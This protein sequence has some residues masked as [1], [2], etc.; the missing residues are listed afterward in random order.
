MPPRDLGP[1][2]AAL[3]LD[4]DRIPICQACLS[5]VSMPLGHGE[6]REAK[7]EARKMAPF[8]WREGLAEPVLEAV[9]RAR[10]RGVPLAAEVLDEL[11][12]GGW[13]SFVAREIVLHLARQQEHR[14]RLRR[15]AMLN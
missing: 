9:R 14:A 6:E 10:D 12:Q 4:V 2:I 7:R 8:L 1:L 11:Q 5:F 13:Q 15:Q 3:D